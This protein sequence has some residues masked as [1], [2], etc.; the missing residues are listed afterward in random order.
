MSCNEDNINTM[1]NTKWYICKTREFNDQIINNLLAINT[2]SDSHLSNNIKKFIKNHEKYMKELSLSYKELESSINN[3]IYN[4]CK[5][6]WISDDI[7]YY[8]GD[9]ESTCKITYCSKCNLEYVVKN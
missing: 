4:S 8:H 5:H 1:I 2:K 9:E 6:E 7:D 3:N